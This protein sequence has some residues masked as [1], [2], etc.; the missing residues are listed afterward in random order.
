MTLVINTA[1]AFVINLTMAFFVINLHVSM[2]ISILAMRVI[3]LLNVI[4]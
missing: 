2:E 1:T 4:N 3:H